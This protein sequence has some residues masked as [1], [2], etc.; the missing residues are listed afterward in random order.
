MPSSVAE[1]LGMIEK[2]TMYCT[3]SRRPWERWLVNIHLSDR[4]LEVKRELFSTSHL[5]CSSTSVGRPGYCHH[6]VLAVKN[7][8]V[9]QAILLDISDGGGVHISL[10]FL[11]VSHLLPCSCH[12]AIISASY[13]PTPPYGQLCIRCVIIG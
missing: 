13:M 2:I 3:S 7:V 5:E 8:D 9:C 11:W 1:S 4:M 12:I 6:P 10:V